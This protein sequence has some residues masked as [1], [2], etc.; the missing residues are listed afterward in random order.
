MKFKFYYRI[1][2]R[3]NEYEKILFL[4]KNMGYDF[5]ERWCYGKGEIS[6]TNS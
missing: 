5:I 4:D 3:C 2:N 6:S 1:K